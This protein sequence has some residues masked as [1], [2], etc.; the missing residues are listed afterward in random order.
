MFFCVSVVVELTNNPKYVQTVFEDFECPDY[1][2]DLIYSATAF[3]WIKE[4]I[5]HPKA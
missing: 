4:E 2:I 5:G 3:H 1:S